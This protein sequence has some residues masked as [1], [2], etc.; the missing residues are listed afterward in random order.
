[1]AASGRTEIVAYELETGDER[2][3]IDAT[4]RGEPQLITGTTLVLLWEGDLSA[5][6]TSDG[7]ILWTTVE[8]FGSPLMNNVGVFG[9]SLFVALNSRPW[10]D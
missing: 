5:V 2:W 6:S 4:G 8:P 1:M 3:H 7:S 10:G 9:S